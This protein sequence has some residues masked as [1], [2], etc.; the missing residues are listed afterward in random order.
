MSELRSNMMMSL[1][2]FV[3]GPQQ[4][5]ENPLGIGGMQL[6]EWLFPLRAFRET[7]GEEGAGHNRVHPEHGMRMKLP[8]TLTVQKLSS[9]GAI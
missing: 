4:S 7:H 6:P 1:D 5:A 2:G 8:A 3:A 9:R